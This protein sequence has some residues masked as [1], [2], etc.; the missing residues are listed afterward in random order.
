MKIKLTTLNGSRQSSAWPILKAL[1]LTCSGATSTGSAGG[2]KI[3]RASN[4]DWTAAA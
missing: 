2:Y 4:A 3:P 1:A